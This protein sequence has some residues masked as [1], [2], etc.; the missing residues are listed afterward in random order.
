V[1]FTPIVPSGAT[2]PCQPRDANPLPL[3]AGTVTWFDYECG[4]G[5]D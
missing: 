5:E 2:L 4:M 3:V 1:M